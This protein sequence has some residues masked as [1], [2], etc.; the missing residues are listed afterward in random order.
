[1]ATCS[2][3]QAHTHPKPSCAVGGG[4]AGLS[5][6]VSPAFPAH[7]EGSKPPGSPG[8]L[9]PSPH[10]LHRRRSSS[11]LQRPTPLGLFS[12]ADHPDH[13]RAEAQ[14]QKGAFGLL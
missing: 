5:G 1:M 4:C 13:L 7:T 14:P 11:H 8:P 10:G 6:A 12:R 9:P 2:Q 3:R